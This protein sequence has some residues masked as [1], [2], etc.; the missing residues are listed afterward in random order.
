MRVG[1]C[2][3]NND[4]IRIRISRLAA[5]VTIVL[6][7]SLLVN[8]LALASVPQ[9][10]VLC[11]QLLTGESLE[12]ANSLDPY[13][14]S[15]S[16]DPQQSP[17]DRKLILDAYSYWFFMHREKILRISAQQRLENAREIR[18]NTDKFTRATDKQLETQWGGSTLNILADGTVAPLGRITGL[19]RGDHVLV[20]RTLML[21]KED[22]EEFFQTK[23]LTSRHLHGFNFD[24]SLVNG[25]YKQILE[26]V[27]PEDLNDYHISGG[28]FLVSTTFARDGWGETTPQTPLIYNLEKQSFRLQVAILIPVEAIVSV[29]QGIPDHVKAGLLGYALI[30]PQP[31]PEAELTIYQVV[32]PEW[33]ATDL[34]R[35]DEE[36]RN[37]KYPTVQSFRRY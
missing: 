7:L 19:K 15:F 23:L 4:L 17:E 32:P 9:V 5:N 20:T 10:R 35:L 16:V 22:L 34:S 3:L 11:R 29:A 6:L 18:V 27:G 33:I 21:S 37:G 31:L 36:Y 13:S 1:L 12:G 30:E 8:P 28:Q 2:F 14:I 26:T 25:F 24:R